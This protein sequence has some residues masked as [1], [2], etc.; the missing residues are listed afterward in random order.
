MRVRCE[1]ICGEAQKK[2]K[3]FHPSLS[4]WGGSPR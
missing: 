2:S 3:L 1:A 4:L